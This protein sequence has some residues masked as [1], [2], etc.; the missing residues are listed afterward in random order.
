MS[1]GKKNYNL[2]IVFTL[3]VIFLVVFVITPLFKGIKKSSDNLLFEKERII[4]L[5][6]KK[7][8]L[9]RTEVLYKNYQSDLARIE[10]YLIDPEVPI[11]F[12]R[13]LENVSDDSNVNLE[14]ISMVKNEESEP[15]P[16]LSFRVLVAGSF[17]DFLR[18][19]EKIENSP[20]LIEILDLNGKR[21]TESELRAREFEG[22]S[23]D[24]VSVSFF[25]KV[26][27]Q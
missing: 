8:S 26:Y 25:F 15:W 11:D 3:L 12:I 6:E 10:E 17:P 21:L 18:F 7:E 13:F 24:G 4:L 16:S 1:T 20:Y 5:Q 23:L 14:I 2:L 27:T 19:L 22:L 9:D